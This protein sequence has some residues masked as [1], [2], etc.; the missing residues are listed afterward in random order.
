[1]TTSIPTWNIFSL[2]H[3]LVASTSRGNVIRKEMNREVRKVHKVILIPI[4]AQKKKNLL[5]V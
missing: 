5:F 3:Q 2:W 4:K 1:M